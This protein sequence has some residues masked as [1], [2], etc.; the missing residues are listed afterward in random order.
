MINVKK[1]SLSTNDRFVLTLEWL[2]FGGA[3]ITF[4]FRAHLIFT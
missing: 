3:K 1:L 2:I 4:D